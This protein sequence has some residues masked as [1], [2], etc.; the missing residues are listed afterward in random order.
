MRVF[1]YIVVSLLMLATTSIATAG[2]EI[3]DFEAIGTIDRLD[4]KSGEI[5]VG[6]MLYHLGQNLI[7]HDAKGRLGG[8]EL[9]RNGVKIG[10]SPMSAESGTSRSRTIYEVWVLPKDYEPKQAED[11]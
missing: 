4:F 11:E 7:I 8:R 6:D 3:P 9:L 1:T 10:I 5:V 2:R